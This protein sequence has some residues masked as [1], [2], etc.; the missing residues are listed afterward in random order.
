MLALVVLA[1]LVGV[2]ELEVVEAEVALLVGVG[3]AGFGSV[4]L[5]GRGR[6]VDVG[7]DGGE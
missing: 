3:Q 5:I 4:G 2:V 6:K 7:L 1:G